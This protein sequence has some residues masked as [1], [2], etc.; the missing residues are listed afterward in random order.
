MKPITSNARLPPSKIS[1]TQSSFFN[2]CAVVNSI[3]KG[4]FVGLYKKAQVKAEM[5]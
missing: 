1:P 3:C 4:R 5:P 2:F